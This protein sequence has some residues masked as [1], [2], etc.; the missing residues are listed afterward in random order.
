MPRRTRIEAGHEGARR[1]L[2]ALLAAAP[3]ARADD[4]ADFYKGRNIQ[5]YI[6]YSPGGGYD[7]YARILARHMGEHIP[8]DPT[9][10]PQNMPGAGACG[11]P[12]ISTPSRPRTAARSP[13]SR[14]AWRWSRCSIQPARNM[15]HAEF[16]WIG[17][18]SDEVSV[19]AFPPSDRGIKTL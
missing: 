3:A 12:T 17:S 5:L 14:A 1:R 2:L 19:C 6:G 9:I 10:V 4:V 8:G 16:T 15:I 13:P 7:A 18:I 11:P